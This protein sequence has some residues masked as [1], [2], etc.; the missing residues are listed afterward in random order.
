M[1]RHKSGTFLFLFLASL[2]AGLLSGCEKRESHYTIGVIQWTEQIQPFI[3]SYKGILDSLN[4][5]GFLE[6]VNLTVDYV[7]VEQDNAKALLATKRFIKKKVALIVTLGTGSTL[8]ALQASQEK[9]T[10]LVFSIVGAPKAT[11]ILKEHNS[12]GPNITGVSMKIPMDEQF[13]LIQEI[14]PQTRRIGILFSKDT[15]QAVA[16]G[17]EAR[18]TAIDMGWQQ[19]TTSL[20]HS[21]LPQLHKKV[22]QLAEY[23]DVIYLPTDPILGTPDN[24]QTI[25]RGADQLGVPVI[26][27]ARDF[28]EAGVLAALHCDFYE[29]GRQTGEAIAQVLMGIAVQTIPPQKPMIK[30]VSLNLDKARKLNIVVNRNVVLK[31]DYLFDD[32]TPP[33]TSSA[34]Q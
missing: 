21:E 27:V 14:L 28:V 16:T 4:D 23:V 5:K 24:I 31:A 33:A 7:N 25:V 15:P 20:D 18:D 12:S 2:V 10:P 3:Q 9:Q 11:G 29:L 34:S 22:R 30:R 13:R 32:F 17:H 8:A 19:I 1:I 6:G 26:G